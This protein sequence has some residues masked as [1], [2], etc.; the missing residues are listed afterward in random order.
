MLANVQ[1][2]VSEEGDPAKFERAVLTEVFPSIPAEHRRNRGPLR[3]G[4]YRSREDLSGVHGIIL[5]RWGKLTRRYECLIESLSGGP[6]GSESPE[7]DDFHGLPAPL[8][9]LGAAI[10]HVRVW[11]V[12]GAIP[13]D[14]TATAA[15]GVDAQAVLVQVRM[16]Q[17]DDQAGFE[18][19]LAATLEDIIADRSSAE[20]AFTSARRHFF[21]FAAHG[22]WDYLCV[23]TGSFAGPAL[24]EGW[25][26]RLRAAGAEIMDV[27]RYDHV[28]SVTLDAAPSGG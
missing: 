21:D 20:R 27:N 13:D 22:V 5:G 2:R 18:K 11:D 12:R 8:T 28:G 1:V 17:S 26:E 6:A 14:A 23:L 3:C 4:L 9:A 24:P 15:E 19:V 10:D 25:D 16:S 7:R